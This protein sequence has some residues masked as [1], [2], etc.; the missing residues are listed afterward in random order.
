MDC[1]DFIRVRTDKNRVNI[2]NDGVK[3]MSSIQMPSSRQIETNN[4]EQEV[5]NQVSYFES[6]HF[7][8][9]FL[10]KRDASN[11]HGFNFSLL[12]GNKTTHNAVASNPQIEVLQLIQ[13]SDI[14]DDLVA[15]I[16]NNAKQTRDFYATSKEMPMLSKPMLLHYAFEKLA[17]ILVL[18]TFRITSSTSSHGLSPQG[19]T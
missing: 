3:T 4:P 13:A 15:E 5:W 8:R 9:N 18:S 14:T 1:C 17:N 2:E 11:F 16:S 6:E 19:Q 7:V 12:I 10:A